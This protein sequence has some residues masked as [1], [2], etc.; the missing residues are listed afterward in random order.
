MKKIR[1]ITV[2]L[3][4]FIILGYIK[5][6]IYH[7]LYYK[8]KTQ[9]TSNIAVV[10][11]KEEDS[12]KDSKNKEIDTRTD[13]NVINNKDVNDKDINNTNNNTS[14]K[15]KDDFSNAIFVGD[16]ITYGFI[17][18]NNTPI[19]KNNVYAKIGSHTFEGVKLLGNNADLIK[20]K[21][22]GNVD[23][24]FIMYGA[25][26]YGY[27]MSDYKRWYKELITHIKTMFPSAKIIVQ[28]VLPI[29]NTSSEPNRSSQP[30]K[31]NKVVKEIA[32]EENVQYLDVAGNI[33]NINS[34]HME[35]G[36]H[37]KAELYPL[38]VK[39]IKENVIN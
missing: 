12:A 30:Q 22:N 1:I 31:L 35:D 29:Q 16:S 21:S 34:L 24:V 28:S 6:F 8:N 36:L 18:T 14:V 4:S 33:Y 2:G 27:D 39:V 5:T 10:T 3:I 20:S 25:N 17:Q 23:Y 7:N 37:F 32:K 26:D 19:S 11:N 13:T 15:L 9:S 38:W